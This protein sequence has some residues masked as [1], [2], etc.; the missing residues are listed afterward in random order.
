MNPDVIVTIGNFATERI[1]N[2]KEIRSIRGQ[3][4]DLNGRTVIPVVHPAAYIY[5]GRNPSMFEEM[6]EDFELIASL[7]KK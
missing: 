1:I 4:F 5:S 3:I 6:K 2:K 7:V